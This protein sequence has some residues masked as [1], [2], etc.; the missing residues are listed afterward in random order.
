MECIFAV[1]TNGVTDGSSEI[2]WQHSLHYT[3]QYAAKKLGHRKDRSRSNLFVLRVIV[4]CHSSRVTV[5][6]TLLWPSSSLETCPSLMQ[7][8]PIL[9]PAPAYSSSPQHFSVVSQTAAALLVTHHS[10]HYLPGIFTNPL[11]PTVPLLPYGYSYKPSCARPGW[12]IICNFLTSGHSDDQGQ[13]YKWRIN[14]VW[15]YPYGNSGCQWVN[16]WYDLLQIG[17][18]IAVLKYFLIITAKH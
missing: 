6:T 10:R 13:N 3:Q 1:L 8:H 9:S 2:L 11:T 5:N 7:Q 12:A 18:L 4:Y 15:H 17:Y 14:P 16:M